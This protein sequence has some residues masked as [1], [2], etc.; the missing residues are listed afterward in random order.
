[1]ITEYELRGDGNSSIRLDSIQTA[2]ESCPLCPDDICVEIDVT[3]GIDVY[4]PETH[5]MGFI[6][7]GPHK[8]IAR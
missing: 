6:G 7:I 8:Q 1:M 5:W 2:W 4:L 3:C